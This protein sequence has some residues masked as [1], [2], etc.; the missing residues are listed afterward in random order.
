MHKQEDEWMNENMLKQPELPIMKNND[1][2]KAFLDGYKGWPIWF[3]VPLASET[4]YRYDLPD[5]YSI[6]IC[7]YRRWCEWR[8]RYT[9]TGLK[10]DSIQT[11]EYLLTPRYHY[12]DD[13]KTNRSALIMHLREMQKN[14]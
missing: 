6:V 9:S 1:Q 13:C 10:P 5:G 14:N 2:R 4:Y 3:E 11:R 12:L 7:E 8:E